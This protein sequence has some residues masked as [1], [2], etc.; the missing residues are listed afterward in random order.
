MEEDVGQPREFAMRTL[1]LSLPAVKARQQLPAALLDV[2]AFL[3][4]LNRLTVKLEEDPFALVLD[5][6]NPRN[7]AGQRGATDTNLQFS[8]GIRG[9]GF[10]SR[11]P[12]LRHDFAQPM[13]KHNPLDGL[14]P[15]LVPNCFRKAPGEEVAVRSIVAQFV[16]AGNQRLHFRLLDRFRLF[17]LNPRRAWISAN[18]SSSE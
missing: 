14:H 18:T 12:D 4:V 2:V 13:D 7:F 9:S 10:K 1:V 16:L 11:E 17:Q 5:G 15:R 8:V 3:P 6:R